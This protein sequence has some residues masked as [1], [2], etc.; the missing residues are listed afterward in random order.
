[1]S[2][3]S[4]FFSEASFISSI[5][6]FVILQLTEC[7]HC[8]KTSLSLNVDRSSVQREEIF[9]TNVSERKNLSSS[10]AFKS[11]RCIY[12]SLEGDYTLE[13]LMTGAF[14]IAY[15]LR[16]VN[17]NIFLLNRSQL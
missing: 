11:W 10:P 8:H 9:F 6:S 1:M 14:T 15:C 13:Q 17:V 16:E 12:D 5:L 4:I 3:Y 7:W 2:D